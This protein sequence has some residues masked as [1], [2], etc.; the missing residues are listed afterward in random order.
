MEVAIKNRVKIDVDWSFI[1]SP[2]FQSVDNCI[3]TLFLISLRVY[4]YFL[5]IIDI[6][7]I[8]RIC[9]MT[10]AWLPYVDYLLFSLV[11]T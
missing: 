5:I 1:S 3:F 9:R 4:E 6:E 8:T 2:N 7:I 10:D 11:F